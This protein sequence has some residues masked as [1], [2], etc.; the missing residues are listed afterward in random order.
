M[1]IYLDIL[2]HPR[3]AIEWI[4]Q[5]CPWK[6]V[7]VVYLLVMSAVSFVVLR[8]DNAFFR[9]VKAK[10]PLFRFPA[11]RVFGYFFLAFVGAGACA[12][13]AFLVH[14]GSKARGDQQSF[15]ALLTLLLMSGTWFAGFRLIPFRSA[16]VAS[17]CWWIALN[18]WGTV[19]LYG[20]GSLRTVL[21]LVAGYFI[22][23]LPFIVSRA[24]REGR[25]CGHRACQGDSVNGCSKKEN[26]KC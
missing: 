2:I 25:R 6:E 4:A 8:S 13:Y 19:I 26:Y 10:W 3:S 12:L 11:M 20:Y 15:E 18:L 1:P 17:T 14:E 16:K 21:I 23:T 24:I 5:D 9:V 7:L 22:L